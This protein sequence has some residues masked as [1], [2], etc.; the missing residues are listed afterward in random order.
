MASPLDS[1]ERWEKKLSC[2]FKTHWTKRLILFWGWHD[3][4][5]ACENWKPLL[6]IL[7]EMN[8]NWLYSCGLKPPTKI[9]IFLL[10]MRRFQCCLYPKK[11]PTSR[12]PYRGNWIILISPSSYMCNWDCI[13]LVEVDGDKWILKTSPWRVLKPQ[14]QYPWWSGADLIW[15]ICLSLWWCFFW[16]GKCSFLKMKRNWHFSGRRAVGHDLPPNGWTC[17]VLLAFGS[18]DQRVCHHA[19]CIL[20]PNLFVQQ[21]NHVWCVSYGLERSPTSNSHH[22]DYDIFFHRV[23]WHLPLFLAAKHPKLFIII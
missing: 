18:S 4:V 10:N 23:N 13:F 14:F 16:G 6:P 9:Y 5:W 12:A 1:H 22:E 15:R 2:F 7:E 8:Q 3:A 17:F 11:S 20:P 19:G 21:C